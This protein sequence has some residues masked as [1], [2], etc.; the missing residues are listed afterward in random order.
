MFWRLKLHL[1]YGDGVAFIYNLFFYRSIPF[2]VPSEKLNEI[3]Q[4][5]NKSSFRHYLS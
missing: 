4:N 1:Y 2:K 3:E 5:K